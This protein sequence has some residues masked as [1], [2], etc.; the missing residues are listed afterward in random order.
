ME[1]RIFGWYMDRIHTKRD[2]VL[3]EENI[4]LLTEGSVHLAE[5]LSK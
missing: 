3:M 1:S 2:T 4:H 5:T